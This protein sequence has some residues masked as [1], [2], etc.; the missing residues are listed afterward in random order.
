MDYIDQH[1]W[2]G[3][4]YFRTNKVNFFH[5]CIVHGHALIL[6]DGLDEVLSTNVRRKIADLVSEF[7]AEYI[8]SPS[9]LAVFDPVE[10]LERWSGF[11]VEIPG[12]SNGNQI[13]ITSRTIGYRY[14]P[15]KG[16][17]LKIFINLK[18]DQNNA[19][20]F[21]RHFF[22]KV[23][24]TIDYAADG[25]FSRVKTKQ[26]R[27][28]ARQRKINECQNMLL[29]T[30][31]NYCSNPMMV[32]LTC[33]HCL[34]TRSFSQFHVRLPLYNGIVS[35]TISRTISSSFSNDALS[36]IYSDIALYLQHYSSSG[37]I[38]RF[39]ILQ[40]TKLSLNKYYQKAIPILELK[41]QSSIFV[42][43][44]N[45]NGTILVA[46][47]LD[48]FGFIHKMYQEF[49][50]AMLLI[51][52]YEN[53]EINFNRLMDIV[54]HH[55]M[56]P[57]FREP[58]LM[59]I[60]WI[61][62]KWT[63]D[64]F[65]TYCLQLVQQTLVTFPLGTLF[66]VEAFRRLDEISS[67]EVMF[68][69]FD[70]LLPDY[71]EYLARGLTYFFD[72]CLNN[73]QDLVCRYLEKRE[74]WE[75]FGQFLLL[76]YQSR[77]KMRN[78]SMIKLFSPRMCPYLLQLNDETPTAEIIV[79]LIMRKVSVEDCS[80]L[81]F[82]QGDLR[83]Y[84]L[85]RQI[86]ASMIHPLMLALIIAL[87]GGLFTHITENGTTIVMFSPDRMHRTS[88]L[89]SKLVE[90][91][92]DFDHD[93]AK[94]IQILINHCE[95][96][97]QHT[98]F[99]DASA[100]TVD[101]LVALLCLKGVDDLMF[102]T[103]T[104]NYQ[105]FPRALNRWKRILF[106][107]REL[108]LNKNTFDNTLRDVPDLFH[109]FITQT[110]NDQNR[111]YSFFEIVLIALPRLVLQRKSSSPF[112]EDHS[113][114]IF[115]PTILTKIPETFSR[116]IYNHDMLRCIL[117]QHPSRSMFVTMHDVFN[118]EE[119]NKIDHSDRIDQLFEEDPLFLVLFIPQFIQPLYRRL[120]LTG[121]LV[122][123]RSN[124]D[125]KSVPFVILLAEVMMYIATASHIWS[126]EYR[127]LLYILE[128]SVTEHN[129]E[130]YVLTMISEVFFKND[131][132]ELSNDKRLAEMKIDQLISH[133]RLA[134]N[135][136]SGPE[137]DVQLFCSFISLIHFYPYDPNLS[138]AC[139][140]Q[141]CRMANEIHD[142][143]LRQYALRSM[144]HVRTDLNADFCERLWIDIERA[145][146]ALPSD[147]PL[148]IVTLLIA[149]ST[150]LADPMQWEA[151]SL[152]DRLNSMPLTEEEARDQEVAYIALKQFFS[153]NNFIPT[154][155]LQRK[156]LSSILSLPS[157][158]FRDYLHN[159]SHFSLSNT[160]L[161]SSMY[162]SL[163]A[164][165]VQILL[166]VQNTIKGNIE[167]KS[168][169]PIDGYV[170]LK[171]TRSKVAQDWVS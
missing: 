157:P 80:K 28:Y 114:T 93:H 122:R 18:M 75:V 21:V 140:H 139:F 146:K 115:L 107:L 166:Q 131:L 155:F 159:P 54:I 25:F 124:D 41:I 15:L 95:R 33:I 145:M 136:I 89:S 9:C 5:D 76:S 117:V 65:R 44:I 69:I 67:D 133:A 37:L 156:N 7:M 111:F 74:R 13:I 141:W 125:G 56:K 144:L 57:H 45:N 127:A 116:T 1:S 150:N 43:E 82:I 160:V 134:I 35:L 142:I 71:M 94:K 55:T 78:W 79:D 167:R 151:D 26:Q 70:A 98:T 59:A 61:H 87:Y 66:L 102:Y 128:I 137:K 113:L 152:L 19:D 162:L 86:T 161:L 36:R 14:Y 88:Q 85:E 108:F 97:I 118:V 103:R 62:F 153:I 109:E 38:D 96:T 129:L 148:L 104:L 90:Y 72:T 22:S 49:F 84:L 169:A 100:A 17:A 101:I 132:R 158:T 40:L 171:I 106:H 4:G 154:S 164:V 2:I 123:T 47:G 110:G 138:Y 170:H 23:Q 16:D 39:D 6:L 27:K 119:L 34:K 168:N 99:T 24:S 163:L 3:K 29:H 143:V 60:E 46:R 68:A 73:L 81:H 10:V 77:D 64:D 11:N 165:D 32:L 12:F 8:R 105:A 126:V 30:D 63:Q 58:L 20:R 83:C 51:R 52:P 91:F 149:G 135:N 92:E 121:R 31:D 112:Y 42:D 48:T 53:G 147:I 130:N 50:V 120:I